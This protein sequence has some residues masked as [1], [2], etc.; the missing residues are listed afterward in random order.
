VTKAGADPLA[1]MAKYPGRFPLLHL[2]DASPAPER[3]IVDV[4]TGTI[5]FTT[6]LKTARSQGL[7]HA[8]VE[9]DFPPGDPIASAR[10]SFNNLAKLSL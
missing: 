4:G 10:T 5:D 1:L 6:V 9:N 8:Y 2:K 7:K 3:K